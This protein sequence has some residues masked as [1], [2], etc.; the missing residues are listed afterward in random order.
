MGRETGTFES[1]QS[2]KANLTGED[3][4][5]LQWEDPNYLFGGAGKKKEA[6]AAIISSE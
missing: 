3:I 6:P 4:A 1:E 2:R 5:D